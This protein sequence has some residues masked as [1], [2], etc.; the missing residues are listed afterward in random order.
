[1]SE[2]HSGTSSGSQ[3]SFQENDQSHNKYQHLL[4]TCPNLT[5]ELWGSQLAPPLKGH[6]VSN[7]NSGAQ[8]PKAQ[9]LEREKI[10]KL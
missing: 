3:S 2:R 4:R 8:V 5:Y 9:S 6:T 7:T 10:S 1:M